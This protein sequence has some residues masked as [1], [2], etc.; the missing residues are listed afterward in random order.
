[1]NPRERV[2]LQKEI[3]AF[4][5]EYG[6]PDVVAG[7]TPMTGITTGDLRNASSACLLMSSTLCSAAR[8]EANLSRTVLRHPTRSD[9]RWTFPLEPHAVQ[10]AEARRCR[11][12][13]AAWRPRRSRL[14]A[15]VASRS[16][17]HVSSTLIGI[18]TGSAP[19]RASTD[20]AMA[21]AP[22]HAGRRL[23]SVA[24]AGTPTALAAEVKASRTSIPAPRSFGSTSLP[25]G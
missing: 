24:C 6:R 3:G 9:N 2:R 23:G 12:P 18:P 10:S 11:S 5:R 7:S 1:M 17:A 4:M 22:M 25:R 19:G 13:V 15:T 20:G 8:E 21:V 14:R 16:P